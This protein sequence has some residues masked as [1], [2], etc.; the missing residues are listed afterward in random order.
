VGGKQHQHNQAIAPTREGSNA[1]VK[2]PQPTEKINAKKT[3]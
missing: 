1:N 2:K 3:T